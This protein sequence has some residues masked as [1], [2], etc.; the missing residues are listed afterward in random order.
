M[1]QHPDEPEYN[2]GSAAMRIRY[3]GVKALWTMARELGRI[4]DQME[5]NDG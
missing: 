4:A 2:P 1:G 5:D 3:A